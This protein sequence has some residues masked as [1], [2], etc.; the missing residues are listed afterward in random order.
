[1]KTL[2]TI[3]LAGA[4]CMAMTGTVS[5][6]P[7]AADA[8]AET[9]SVT[10]GACGT[11]TE[12]ELREDDRLTITGSGEIIDYS[13]P[14]KGRE[15]AAP[16]G[17]D[18]RSVKIGEGVTRIGSNAFPGNTALRSISLPDS[19]TEIGDYAF[20]ATAQENPTLPAT[21]TKLGKGVF[22]ECHPDTLTI[23]NPTLPLSTESLGF[24]ANDF[25]GLP[26]ICGYEGSTAQ[27]LAM[28]NG[29]PFRFIGDPAGDNVCGQNLRWT[30]DE[31]T[32]TLT[33]SGFPPIRSGRG[34]WSFCA[35]WI[36]AN[37]LYIAISSGRFANFAKE[38][39]S[40]S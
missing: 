4:L 16:W 33:I 36:S 34:S 12:W 32:G 29:Y 24:A 28:E 7:A 38:V 18:L 13:D 6:F 10:R 20:R 21:V 22:K 5:V 31:A 30:L 1:M 14:E 15:T 11:G 17:T 19:L 26:T 37:S 23:L 9:S 39:F 25:F 8:P 3:A 35:D 2:R 40:F 27:T